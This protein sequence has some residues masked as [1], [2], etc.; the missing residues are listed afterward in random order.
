MVVAL[1]TVPLATGLVTAQAA[2]P[3]SGAAGVT[4]S[5]GSD[6]DQDRNGSGDQG[7]GSGSSAQGDW[8]FLHHCR[9]QHEWWQSRCGRD[10]GDMWH[11][12]APPPLGSW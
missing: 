4:A 9:Q 10:G 3:A 11:R 6:G 1:L 8:W 7:G 5:R 2:P 12:G